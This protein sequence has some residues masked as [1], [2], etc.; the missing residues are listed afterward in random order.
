MEGKMPQDGQTTQPR[1]LWARLARW[2]KRLSIIAGFLVF[3]GPPIGGA[4]A[5][6]QEIE[7][8]KEGIEEKLAETEQLAGANSRYILTVRY[9]ELDK[10]RRNVGLTISE[11]R[12][13]CSLGRELEYFTQCPSRSG[14]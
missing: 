13:F 1:G 4:W 9:L 7:D 11:Y 10:K 12:E 3:L 5:L 2:Q 8:W 6:Y 14:D